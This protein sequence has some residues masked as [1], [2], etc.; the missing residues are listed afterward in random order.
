[1]VFDRVDKAIEVCRNNPGSRLILSGGWRKYQEEPEC[2]IMADYALS[3]GVPPEDILLEDAGDSTI[4]MV[5]NSYA[6]MCSDYQAED[7]KSVPG[8][9]LVST[10]YH[11]LRALFIAR[12]NKIKCIGYGAKTKLHVSMNAFVREYVQYL[13]LTR[14]NHIILLILF[15]VI[16]WVGN[17]ILM[18]S[19]VLSPRM[20]QPV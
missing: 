6:L 10:A 16:F 4:A 17:L 11:V 8:F 13:K 19:G 1:M 9:A 5:K 15:T 20:W 12:R 3:R 18:K 7:G 2:R 14:R